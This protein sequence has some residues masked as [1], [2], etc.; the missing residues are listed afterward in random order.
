LLWGGWAFF[1]NDDGD[2]HSGI[3]SGTAQGSC[4]FII[5]LFMTHSIAI[6]FN[7]FSSGIFRIFFPPV[8]TVGITGTMLISVHIM[9]GTP[10]ILVTVSPALTVALVFSFFTVYK[11]HVASQEQGRINDQE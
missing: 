9:V 10:S 7:K 5:T 3:I 2:S 6:Q 8:I 1:I 4:S 11:L